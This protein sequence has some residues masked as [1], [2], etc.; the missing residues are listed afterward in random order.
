M[1]YERFQKLCMLLEQRI[2]QLDQKIEQIKRP[3]E[4]EII[5]D[6]D[7][8]NRLNVSKRTTSTW[9]ELGMIRHSIIRGKIY[10]F[11]SDVLQMIQN[12]AVPTLDG[13]LKIKLKR[14]DN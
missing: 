2:Q 4:E 12:Y 9:R 3:A 10:Y 13:S 8:C 11:Y 5:D 6:V 7:L 14:N 1:S